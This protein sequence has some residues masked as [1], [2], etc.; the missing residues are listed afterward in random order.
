MSVP[1]LPVTSRTIRLLLLAGFFFSGM[2]VASVVA[3]LLM[4]GPEDTM[5]VTRSSVLVSSVIQNIVAFIVPVV[6]LAWLVSE[7]PWKELYL[8]EPPRIPSVI[9]VILIC[10]VSVPAMNWLTAV[11]EAI[12]F[13][14][15]LSPLEELLRS[16]ENQA[17]ASTQ[18]IM[19]ETTVGG[20]IVN[21]LIV[22]ILTG[23]GE[24]MFFRGGV[25]NFIQRGDTP[26]RPWIAIWVTAVIFSAMHFQFF[27]FLPRMVLGAYFGYLLVWTR[28]LWIPVIAHAL[29]NSLALCGGYIINTGKLT[30]DSFNI[31]VPGSGTEWMAAVS[32]VMIVVTVAFARKYLFQT[33]FRY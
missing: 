29:N 4:K 10:V 24:E 16:M 6:L 33:R 19:N 5:T 27:G 1:K 8:T 12:T 28:S 17:A 11:N 21:I 9:G 31:G 14:D 25:Q 22:G 20:L 7:R 32:T 23:L 13:P 15:W 18:E 2:M 26:I 3:M 30:E